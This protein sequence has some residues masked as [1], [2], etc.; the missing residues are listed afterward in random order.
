MAPF[1]EEHFLIISPG[2]QSTQAQFGLPESLTP[3][4]HTFAT[5]M[6]LAPDGKTYEPYKIKASKKDGSDEEEMV[7]YLEDEEGAIWPLKQGRI[8]NMEC[9]LAF[10]HHVHSKLQPGLHVGLV[11]V[12]QPYWTSK[13]AEDITR[14]VFETFKI[15]GFILIDAALAATY[16]YGLANAT[17]IDVGYE[18]VDVTAITDFMVSSRGGVA[19]CGGDNMTQVLLAL[20]D[21][22]YP[23]FTMEMAEQLKKTNLVEVLP[24][25]TP[26][27]GAE[28]TDEPVS[29]PAGA[30]S[31]GAPAPGPSVRITEPPRAMDDA[32]AGDD[33]L[34]N[35]EK[36]DG[37][38]DVASI[39]ASG[40]AQDILAKKE[41]DKADKAAAKKANKEREAAEV[42]AAHKARIPN[43]RRCW[44][45]WTYEG[46]KSQSQRDQDKEMSD[47]APAAQESTGDQNLT[48]GVSA[49]TVDEANGP[50]KNA[51][52]KHRKKPSEDNN[53][54]LVR[55]EYRIGPERFKIVDRYFI[56]RI[57]DEVYRVVQSIRDLSARQNAWDNLILCGGG[58]K[59]RGFKDVL[60]QNL[61]NRYLISPSSATMFMSELPSNIATPSGTGS[62]TPSASFTPTPHGGG[63]HQANSL[64]IAATTAQNPALNPNL[65]ASYNA[66]QSHSSH[67]QTPTAIK[68]VATPTYFPELKDFYDANFLGACIAAKTVFILDG[69]TTKGLFLTRNIYNE[70]GP[71]SIHQM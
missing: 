69:G 47:S 37:V 60:L 29:N 63:T 17:V 44:A 43:S 34:A 25:G 21:Q 3:A 49:M 42:A 45:T 38:L 71:G 64:L 16:G 68:Y 55:K 54:G 12:A 24:P 66:L 27:P 23:E 50:Q 67:S 14:F 36:E 18:K 35:T 30:L 11:I 13:D 39:L 1:R 57:A 52:K 58:A 7:E 65:Q 56:D 31:T 46:A 53:Q 19:G 62:M 61:L 22:Q 2:S 48:D 26:L 4:Q 51:L 9:F 70:D 15:S 8:V 5:R 59:L 20:V 32:E 41:K 40:R 28:G 6:F 10:L 33:E